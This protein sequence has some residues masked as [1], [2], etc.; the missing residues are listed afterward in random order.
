M[1]MPFLF[2]RTPSEKQKKA[3][4]SG[5]QNNETYKRDKHQLTCRWMTMSHPSGDHRRK[6]LQ[7]QVDRLAL[8][9]RLLIGQI[10]CSPSY[11]APNLFLGPGLRLGFGAGSDLA[12][13]MF[14]FRRYDVE[15]TRTPDFRVGG[16]HI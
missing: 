13:A 8:H 9:I 3:R 15:W 16:P 11:A 2:S 6:L 1:M 7:R 14:I 4:S 10:N 12:L 5:S